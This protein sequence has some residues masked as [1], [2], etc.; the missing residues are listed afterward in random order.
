MSCETYESLQVGLKLVNVSDRW[1]I[2]KYG[3]D[4]HSKKNKRRSKKF[5]RIKHLKYVLGSF[6]AVTTSKV[7]LKY[8]PL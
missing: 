6:P 7:T 3:T 4:K 8:N 5:C 1:G 2:I